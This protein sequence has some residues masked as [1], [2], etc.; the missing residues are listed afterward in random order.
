MIYYLPVRLVREQ[1]IAQ[2]AARNTVGDKA[3][4]VFLP[5]ASKDQLKAV[6]VATGAVFAQA[7]V[8]LRL[9]QSPEV[10]DVNFFGAYHP[11]E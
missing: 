8:G 5:D 3:L 4:L 6:A 9:I 7:G 2:A 11:V 10:K 1:L